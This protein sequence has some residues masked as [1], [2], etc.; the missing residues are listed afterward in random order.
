MNPKCECGGTTFK[1][2]KMGGSIFKLQWTT[3]TSFW[4]GSGFDPDMQACNSCGKIHFFV[5]D[6]QK[7]SL[8]AD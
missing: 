2:L 7:D 6:H 3:K 8:E 1:K 4:K 5:P